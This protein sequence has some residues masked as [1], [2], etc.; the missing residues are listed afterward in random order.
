MV[1]DI[2]IVM[3]W[4]LFIALFPMTFFWLRRAYRIF[5]QKDYS[6]VALKRG[7]SPPNPKKWA[8]ATGLVNL[9]AGGVTL[10]AIFGVVF[11]LLPYRTWSTMAGMTLWGK[12]FAD[13]IVSRQAH[14]FTL[15]KKSPKE[16]T[17]TSKD[18]S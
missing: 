2:S 7:E 1:F 11:A 12:I 10:A 4:I 14:P 16:T 3:T 5:I 15:G 18:N 17:P 9:I 8:P 6:E 13:F